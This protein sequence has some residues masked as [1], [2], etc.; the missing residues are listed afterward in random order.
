MTAAVQEHVCEASDEQQR[1]RELFVHRQPSYRLTEAAR[2]LGM[3]RGRL[4]RE[5]KA[6]EEDA[7]RVN[8][9]WRFSWRQVA[10]LA[11]RQW[12]LAEIH[13]TLGPDARTVLPPL[14]G[15][16]TLTVRLPEYLIRAIEVSAANED[17]TIDDWLQREL[18]DFAG[19]VA[20]RMNHVVPGFRSA[21]LWPGGDGRT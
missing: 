10:Y 11:L 8:G 13:D 9:R 2:L 4:E 1:I 17:T 20:D 19:T 5:A 14:L 7:Y 12:T 16:R 3:T 18:T 6:D 15:L 21:Y